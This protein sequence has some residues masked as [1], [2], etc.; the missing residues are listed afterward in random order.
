MVSGTELLEV[1]LNGLTIGMVY[2]LVAAG[3]SIIFGVMDVLNV[4][5]GELL[6]LGA[7]IAFAVITSVNSGGFWIALIVAPLLIGIVGIIIERFTIR[8]VYGRGHLAHVL[9]T[10]G[11]LLIFY[12]IK[13]II[14]GRGQLLF[15]APE[16]VNYPVNIL[17][18]SYSLYNYFMIIS[19]TFIALLT[20]VLLRYTRFGLVIRAG[21]EDRRM[22]RNLGINIDRYYTLVFGVGA[23]LAAFG[24][25]VLGGYQNV[26]PEMGNAVIIPAFVIVVLGGLGSFWGAVVGGIS[27]GIVQSVVSTWVP[28]LQGLVLFLIMIGVLLV[29]PQGLLGGKNDQIE[30]GSADPSDFVTD[31]GGGVLSSRARSRLGVATV[32]LLAL[33]PVFNGIL[34][35][36]FIVSLLITVLIWALFA[37]SIDII[38]GYSGLISLGHTMFYGVGAY[39]AMLM[40][41]HVSPSAFLALGAAVVVSVIV[42]WLVSH[43]A[44]RVS[45]VYFVMITLAFAELFYEGVFKFDLLGRSN[46]LFGAPEP[47]YGIA[48]IGLRFNE[49][50]VGFGPLA[51]SGAELFFYFLLATVVVSYMI[52][53]RTMRSPFGTVLMSIRESEVRARFIGYDVQLFKR[54]AFILSGT[55]GGVAGAMFALFNG[56]ATPSLLNWINSGDVIVMAVLGGTGTLYGPMLGAGAFTGFGEL[57]SSYIQ[58]WRLLLGTLF[59]LVVLFL[60]KGFV[61]LPARIKQ[62][63]SRTSDDRSSTEGFEPEVDD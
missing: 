46:G 59:V 40:L 22:V 54:K 47:L 3:L 23:A 27:V 19:G 56:Y 32:G 49:V 61:S 10:F 43:L 24:G 31:L 9:L 7:Y 62:R 37:M 17:G 4:T 13:Q 30:A 21:S 52:A 2:V 12:D 8:R 34:Y 11:F 39:T 55:L 33:V 48:G 18:F 45:G 60:P 6:A 58:W 53:R 41:V 63:V 29:R 36:E 42:G 35:S 38:L 50:I 5:H 16:I 44:L 20:W 25:V 26:N 28:E 57:V 51:F 1:V 15:S 14:W